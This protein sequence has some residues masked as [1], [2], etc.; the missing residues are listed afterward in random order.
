MPKIDVGFI[1]RRKPSE[2]LPDVPAV[3][4]RL[5]AQSTLDD[6]FQAFERFL[7]ACGYQQASIDRYMAEWTCD[8]A[9]KVHSEE[10]RANG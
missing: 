10:D 5:D 7:L 2:F 3:S 9:E 8:A 1:F 6:M 4:V